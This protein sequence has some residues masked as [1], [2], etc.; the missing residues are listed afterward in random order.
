MTSKALP[1]APRVSVVI[2]TAKRAALVQRAV[3]SV[4]NQTMG[5]LEV[6]VVVDGPDHETAS[7]LAHLCDP[8][9][10]V[11]TNT[12]NLGACASR[13]LGA[14]MARGEWLAFLD[15]D[16][17]WLP[18]KLERQLTAAVIFFGTV[19]VTCR[20]YV[21]TPTSRFIWPRRLYDGSIALDDY[22]FDRRSIF[23]G[24]GFI[25]TS[26]LLIL[27]AVF[28]GLRFADLP[29][30]EE[31]DLLLRAVIGNHAALVMLPEALVVHYAEAGTGSLSASFEWRESL[32]WLRE[33]ESLM[34]RRAISGFCLTIVAPQPAKAKDYSAI[35]PLLTE[36]WRRGKP[37]PM[38]LLLF[39]TFWVVPPQFRQ[40]VRARCTR[41]PFEIALARPS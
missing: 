23:K 28:D 3:A 35:L 13:N 22:L 11:V 40:R 9:V 6:I 17:E 37:T 26:S 10:R 8:R 24:D 15:D 14:D 31:W 20:S 32:A 21:F 2:P 7:A 30:H 25:Q 29:Q 19:I 33:R 18:E 4:L 38:Q 39:V 34:S 36:A 12:R 41:R 16:D 1:R 27:K 5:E